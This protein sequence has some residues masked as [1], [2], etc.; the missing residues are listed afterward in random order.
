MGIGR[1]RTG[2]LR[3]WQQHG[4]RSGF[5]RRGRGLHCGVELRGLQ[6][7]QVHSRHGQGQQQ[8]TCKSAPSSVQGHR[9]T[10]AVEPA[11][12][13]GPEIYNAP[14][15]FDRSP[16]STMKLA[17]YKDGSRDGQLVVVSRDLGLAHYATGIAT[18]LQQV[19]D[20][21]NYLAPL[22]Q[23]L[24]ETL[25]HGKARH[26]F[27]FEPQLC[28]A[29]LPRAFGRTL[30]GAWPAH[31]ALRAQAEGKDVGACDDMLLPAG[32]TQPEVA[33]G[34]AAVVADLPA[35]VAPDLALEGIRLLMLSVD[36]S[37]LPSM[38]GDPATSLLP[39]ASHWAPVAVTLDEVG[40]G[41]QRG[42]LHANL[43]MHCRGEAWGDIDCAQ[44]MYF[45]FGQLI[46]DAAR[47]RPLRAGSIVSAG[48]VSGLPSGLASASW[49]ERAA[50]MQLARREW[51][52]AAAD[53]AVE[54]ATTPRR[55]KQPTTPAPSDDHQAPA[56]LRDGDSLRIEVF[57]T[58]GMSVFG[59]IEQ[60]LLM[61]PGD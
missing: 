30:A 17:S 27:A 57:G 23:D 37:A 60:T 35:G 13:A 6:Q 48:P 44:G 38:A 43:R 58:D 36:W 41:W 12:A 31:R 26:A 56:A 34:L 54:Q 22:L 9:N 3:R 39:F 7:P 18:R 5:Q 33:A 24:S 32:V 55:R 19:L 21:W 25:N 42:R 4:C 51:E 10:G 11:E 29:P 59:G 15:R 40:G 8:G 28:T 46:A 20:D 49:V 52:T 2:G 16:A 53:T 61:Q 14:P 1:R 45:H 50:R 47:L